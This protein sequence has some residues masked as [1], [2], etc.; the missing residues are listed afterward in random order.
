M[1]VQDNIADDMLPALFDL[2]TDQQIT[3]ASYLSVLCLEANV[4][5]NT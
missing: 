4:D 3:D 1:F 5:L 2:V